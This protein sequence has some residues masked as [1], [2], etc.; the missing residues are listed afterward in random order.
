MRYVKIK[1]RILLEY[2]ILYNLNSNVEVSRSRVMMV[3]M[4]VDVSKVS[5]L[6]LTNS[7]TVVQ[8]QSW[9]LSQR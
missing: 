2:K 4:R 3:E 5:E 7:A 9:F 1:I 6:A 8:L